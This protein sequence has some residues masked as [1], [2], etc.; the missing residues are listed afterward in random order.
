MSCRRRT[1]SCPLGVSVNSLAMM[2]ATRGSTTSTR[3]NAFVQVH[4]WHSWVLGY[5][6]PTFRRAE[7]ELHTIQPIHS[8][9]LLDLPRE[10]FL[11]LPTRA[12]QT[13]DW[14]VVVDMPGSE[15]RLNGKCGFC[16][17]RGFPQGVNLKD[18]WYWMTF[19][20]G[21]RVPEMALL[22]A[23]HLAALPT[24]P[25]G[26]PKAPL[27]ALRATSSDAAK[28][29]I[30]DVSLVSVQ[31]RVPRG[32]KRPRSRFFF[33]LSRERVLQLRRTRSTHGYKK[34]VS[35][36]FPEPK[37]HIQLDTCVRTSATLSLQLN[38]R[39]SRD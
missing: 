19:D 14:A 5:L 4:L 8:E 25:P 24:P 38:L 22:P 34:H 18:V 33:P 20:A 28:R 1:G 23:V 27:E 6:A 30:T 9:S 12:P 36:S 7:L 31:S 37:R 13:G 21:A 17:P 29:R 26:A 39:G 10:A 11:P 2:S 35:A 15:A 16:G 32:P 3:E